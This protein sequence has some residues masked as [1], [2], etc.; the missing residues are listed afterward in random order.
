[1][2]RAEYDRRNEKRKTRKT[3]GKL[4]N[5]KR[6]CGKTEIL[7]HRHI[8]TKATLAGARKAIIS[9]LTLNRFTRCNDSHLKSKRIPFKLSLWI[10]YSMRKRQFAKQFAFIRYNLWQYWYECNSMH[11]WITRRGRQYLFIHWKQEEYFALLVGILENA[12]RSIDFGIWKMQ[13]IIK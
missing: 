1:M 12:F 2:Y 4:K 9:Q 6:K 8:H 11:K 10:S 5:Q 13:I 7:F 3:S